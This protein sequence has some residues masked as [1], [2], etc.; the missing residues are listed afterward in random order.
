M[1]FLKKIT[2]EKTAS[3]VFIKIG[4]LL[5]AI[6]LWVYV[7]S[8]KTSEATFKIPITY[9][10]LSSNLIVSE[11]SHN[12]VNVVISGKANMVKSVES[13][14]FRAIIDFKDAEAGI[15]KKIPVQLIK[16]NVPENINVSTQKIEATVSLENIVYK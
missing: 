16:I 11:I 5:V 12:F 9:Q 2:K 8:G 7:I 14:D 6:I 1:K 3:P 15:V 13:K 4:S 10:N